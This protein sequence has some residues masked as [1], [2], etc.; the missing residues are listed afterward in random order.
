MQLSHNQGMSEVDMVDDTNHSC[1][2]VWDTLVLQKLQQ[3]WPSGYIFKVQDLPQDNL[4]DFSR[5]ALQVVEPPQS[6]IPKAYH[7]YVDA[8]AT[9]DQDTAG[10]AVAILAE[11]A[12]GKFAC[13]GAF[14]APAVAAPTRWNIKQQISDYNN[15]LADCYQQHL[16]AERFIS[17]TAEAI[18]SFGRSHGYCKPVATC[19]L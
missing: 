12:N 3:K 18:G 14:G 15:A 11:S 17:N 10:C 16:G 9:D 8:S 7:L 1:R 4:R 19:Q 5:I 6:F 2:A 13:E